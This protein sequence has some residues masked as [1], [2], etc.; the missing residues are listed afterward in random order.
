[1]LLVLAGIMSQP[2]APITRTT[3]TVRLERPATVTQDEWARAPK[4]IRR[5]T[6]VHDEPNEPIV[7][8]LIEF[9]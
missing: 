7:L 8:R 3:A 5:E 6:I 9:Q 1:M 4:E 2:P